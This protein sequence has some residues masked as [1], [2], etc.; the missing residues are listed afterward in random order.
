MRI[1]LV[2]GGQAESVEIQAALARLP[3]L[4]VDSVPT[5]A[6]LSLGLQKGGARPDL[7][8]VDLD[9][10]NSDHVTMLRDLRK[11]TGFENMP[12]IALIDRNAVHGPLRAMRAGATDVLFK[13]VDPNEARDVFSRVME[14]KQINRPGAATVGKA[15]VFMHLSGGAGAT[16]LAVNTACALARTPRTKQSCLIDLDIQ[17]GNAASLLDLPST[18]PMQEFIDDPGRLDEAMLEGMMLRHET[19]LHV[20]TA[21]RTLLPLNA[22]NADGVRSLVD[23]ARRNF[24]FVI[25]DLPVVL[26]PWTDGVLKSASAIYLVAT[27]SVPSAHRV[28]KFLELLREEGVRELPIKLVANRAHRAGRQGNDI[29]IAQFEKAVGRKVDHAIPNDYSLIS[30]S[31]GQG[32]PAVRLKPSS[33]FSLALNEMLAAEFGKETLEQPKRRLFPFGRV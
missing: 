14:L 9:P 31:H 17:F 25:V 22:Y 8:M 7:V 15:I 29:T 1:L 10:E 19:G 21:P 27:M 18:S 28:I 16:T 33:P 4:V 2:S 32:R 6:R 30:L 12:V 3:G 26:A 20:L 23:V 13:P 11:V 5:L 24:E